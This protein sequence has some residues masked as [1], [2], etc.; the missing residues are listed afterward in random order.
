MSEPGGHSGGD[1]DL[2]EQDKPAGRYDR[3]V[4]TMCCRSHTMLRP[5]TFILCDPPLSQFRQTLLRCRVLFLRGL[6]RCVRSHQPATVIFPDAA[7]KAP[8][9]N[10]MSI[11]RKKPPRGKH[12]DGQLPPHGH[13]SCGQNHRDGHEESPGHLQSSPSGHACTM[14]Q[15][16]SRF[17]CVIIL[18]VSAF[19]KH[20]CKRGDVE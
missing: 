2:D 5:N 15:A 16:G 3:E 17:R 4:A 8:S 10:G 13:S 11:N 20:V 9:R 6:R 19:F 14:P 12:T 18:V 1:D 7:I